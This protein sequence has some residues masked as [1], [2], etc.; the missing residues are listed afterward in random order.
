MRGGAEMKFG[1]FLLRQG[2]DLGIIF[3]QPLLDERFITL[4][5][6]APR[7]LTG[8]AQ[9]RQQPAHRYK[10]QRDLEFILDQF[11]DHPAGP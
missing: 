1:F 6:A 8:E 11:G 5:G 10:T 4:Q 3:L 7:P 9:L 2:L